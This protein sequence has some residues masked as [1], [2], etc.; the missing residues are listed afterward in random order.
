MDGTRR[1]LVGVVGA[2]QGVRGEVRVKAYTGDPRALGDYGALDTDA[3]RATLKVVSL[4]PLKS[5]M[6]VV[7]FEGIAD[8][9]AAAALTNTRLYVDRARLPPPGK[10]EF[11]QI[12]LI[13]LA[14]AT[15]DGHDLGRVVA[16]QNFGA[17]DL[18]EIAPPVGQT[19]LVPFTKAFVPVLD[20]AAGRLVVEPGVL[21]EEDRLEDGTDDGAGA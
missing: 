19:M 2:A 9:D 11:Y 1:V 17:G 20:F 16:V 21:V 15:P 5:D 6:L 12:D 13:G 14:A 7:R 3:G 8:R 4:R 18:L 10:E